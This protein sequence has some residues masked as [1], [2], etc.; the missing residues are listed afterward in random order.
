[1]YK[2]NPRKRKIR[3]WSPNTV[4]VQVDWLLPKSKSLRLLVSNSRVEQQA[5]IPM[6]LRKRF[7]I[8]QLKRTRRSIGKIWNL[9]RR[10]SIIIIIF[11]YPYMEAEGT[12]KK[13]TKKENTT[14]PQIRA[15]KTKNLNGSIEK[16]SDYGYHQ[17]KKTENTK[18]KKEITCVSQ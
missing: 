11:I 18:R 8:A 14:K 10:I 3:R 1:M 16:Q 7:K 6:W 4:A 5:T 15:T 13:Q 12:K 9:F 2:L 17:N